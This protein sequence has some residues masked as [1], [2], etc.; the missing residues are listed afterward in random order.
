MDDLFYAYGSDE[1]CGENAYLFLNKADLKAIGKL[2]NSLK[3]KIFKM[4]R[5]SANEGVID[6]SGSTTPYS[7]MKDLTALSTA[8]ASASAVT[9][10]MIYG[11][12]ANYLLG[13]FGGFTIRIDSSYKA[14]ERLD[15]ILGDVMVG[16]NVIVDKGFVIA[17]L[18]KAT[19]G[20]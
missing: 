4:Q 9:P 18:P 5:I 19:N 7:I 12:P 3:E 13:L 17:N 14:A 2:C 10:T 16:G 1:A 8:T 6:D 11:D 20:G 15:T